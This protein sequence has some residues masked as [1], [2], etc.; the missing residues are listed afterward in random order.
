RQNLPPLPRFQ[1][2]FWGDVGGW[3][4]KVS[5][6]GYK[7][8]SENYETLI[9]NIGE[10]PPK[11]PGETTGGKISLD[12]YEKRVAFYQE[13]VARLI[14]DNPERGPAIR[15]EAESAGVRW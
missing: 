14:I 6:T 3:I 9:K 4:N 12:Q 7:K 5:L 10:A 8:A 11:I 15:K 13:F 2:H 1:Q